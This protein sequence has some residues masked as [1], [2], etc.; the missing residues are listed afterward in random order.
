M[1]KY[2]VYV[3]LLGTAKAEELLVPKWFPYLEYALLTLVSLTGM[4]T[5]GCVCLKCCKACGVI[6]DNDD[7]DDEKRNEDGSKK[8]KR[9]TIIPLDTKYPR[10]L[11]KRSGLDF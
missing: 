7:N 4:M 1:F 11:N 10:S 5:M 3:Y 9:D 8:S 2:I 6:R